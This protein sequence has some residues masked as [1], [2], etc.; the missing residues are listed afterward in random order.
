MWGTGHPPAFTSVFPSVTVF[1]L[2]RFDFGFS[3]GREGWCLNVFFCFSTRGRHASG[4]EAKVGV[5]GAF[6]WR[7][8]L[9]NTEVC[10]CRAARL[11]TQ[12]MAKLKF[13]TLT[14]C[15][16]RSVM[17]VFASFRSKSMP[18]PA[19]AHDFVARWT[20]AWTLVVRDPSRLTSPAVVRHE[21]S[22]TTDGSRPALYLRIYVLAD[23][24]PFTVHMN[25]CTRY[26]NSTQYRY[27]YGY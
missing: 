15:L 27:T 18:A 10:K 12:G 17:C 1:T 20:G 26:R 22:R 5:L 8:A 13:L 6:C 24:E 4:R 2:C 19:T 23:P 9:R 21:Y 14:R 7:G 3:R 25:R 16:K 11:Y